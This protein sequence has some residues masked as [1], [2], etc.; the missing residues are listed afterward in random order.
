[1][2]FPT[3]FA[4]LLLPAFVAAQYQ[5]VKEYTGQNF[6]DDWSFYNNCKAQIINVEVH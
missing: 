2:Y 5:M 6:F 3:L 1:M 4:S